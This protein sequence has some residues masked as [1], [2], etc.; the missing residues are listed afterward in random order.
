MKGIAIQT[1]LLLLVGVLVVGILVYLVYK[2]TTGPS[3]SVADCR[4]SLSTICTTCS[5]TSWAG[6]LST[7]F[8]NTINACNDYPEFNTFPTD[9]AG[10][11]NIITPCEYLGIK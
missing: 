9:P 4:A 1:I 7:D 3:L 8:K 5:L 11:V 6:D 2:Y 10:C